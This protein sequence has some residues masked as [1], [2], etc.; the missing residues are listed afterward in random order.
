MTDE[1]T[2]VSRVLAGEREAF[3][4]L[5]KQYERLVVH[6]VG[7]V[8]RHAEDREEI[9]QD[10]FM[11]VYQNLGKFKFESRLSTWIATIAYRQAV[12]YV[13][14]KKAPVTSIQE[15]E[16]IEHQLM[17]ASTPESMFE[18]RDLDDFILKMVDALSPA[19]KT[20]LTL[21]HLHGMSYDEIGEA[22]GMPEGT[23]KNYLFR[24]RHLLKEKIKAS[25]GREVL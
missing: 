23:V 8:V 18:D 14:S 6:M 24:A 9:C 10:V 19:Y 7:R 12:N 15:D 13:R 3:V 20:V 4:L 25:I 17:E 16:R 21:Y 2:L 1:K 5:V 11:R 22:T